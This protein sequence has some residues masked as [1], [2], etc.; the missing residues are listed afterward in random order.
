ME[1]I[2]T[3]KTETVNGFT[4][5]AQLKDLPTKGIT[6]FGISESEAKAIKVGSTVSISITEPK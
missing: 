3:Q 6:L 5:S 1:F 4:I 2:I